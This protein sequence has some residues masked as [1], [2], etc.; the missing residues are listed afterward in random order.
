MIFLSKSALYVY[1]AEGRLIRANVQSGNNVS[2]EENTIMK[3]TEQARFT[4][5]SN[6]EF[7]YT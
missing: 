7:E 6:G 5:K 2:V 4:Y 3:E 1:N